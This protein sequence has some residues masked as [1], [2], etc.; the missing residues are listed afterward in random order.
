MTAGIQEKGKKPI[1]LRATIQ[2]L[3][4]MTAGIREKDGKL[5]YLAGTMGL[6]PTMHSEML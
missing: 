4:T 6:L 3:R 5:T 1:Y 2:L